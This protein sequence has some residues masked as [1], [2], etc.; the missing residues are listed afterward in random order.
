VK[1]AWDDTQ[2]RVRDVYIGWFCKVL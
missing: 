1:R 2:E